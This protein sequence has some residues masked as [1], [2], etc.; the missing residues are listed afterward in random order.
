M[1]LGPVVQQ[2]APIPPHSS[3][4]DR[5]ASGTPADIARGRVLDF[6]RCR[7]LDKS[8]GCVCDQV[9]L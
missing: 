8:P 4:P 5:D 6:R 9:D 2:F 1:P 3:R 7:R